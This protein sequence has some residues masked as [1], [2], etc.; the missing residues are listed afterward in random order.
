MIGTRK[1]C[2]PIAEQIKLIK[3]N[4]LVR[5]GRVII[6]RLRGF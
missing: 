5:S 6:H 1:A 3:L 4:V 2:V